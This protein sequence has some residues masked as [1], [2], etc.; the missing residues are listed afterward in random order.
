VIQITTDLLKKIAPTS[1]KAVAKRDRILELIVPALNL[2]LPQ[3][4]ITTRLRVCHF[5]AQAAHETMGFQTLDELG[6][7]AYF[8]EHYDTR[9][10]LGNTAARDGD[11]ALYHGRGIFQLTGKS[12]YEIFGARIGKDLVNHPE[13]A[14]DGPTSV[15]LA[16]LY[17][18]DRK[19]NQWAD[20][21]N[22]A[23]VTLKINGGDNGIDSRRTYLNRCFDYIVDDGTVVPTPV[24]QPPFIPP[25]PGRKPPIPGT[26]TTPIYIPSTPVEPK[27]A[28]TRFWEAVAKF[29]LS[30][31]GSSNGSGRH[32][33]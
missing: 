2:Y 10:D 31:K 29:I 4:G 18:T 23:K 28:W 7:D 5:L 6:G 24:T 13:I 21:N 22:L 16:C 25:I 26:T 8:N 15:L 1:G 20:A 9:T 14:E 11:G 19:I 32:D 17:W 33:N 12:N 27:S 3:Y 30:L